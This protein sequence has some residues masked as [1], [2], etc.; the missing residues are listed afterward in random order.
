[1]TRDV[2]A[3]T[4]YAEAVAGG[5]TGTRAQWRD[6]LANLPKSPFFARY[7]QTDY[8]TAKAAFDEGRPL[9]AIN[10]DDEML[11]CHGDTGGTLVFGGVI[12][13]LA[14]T[15]TLNDSNT[16]N[17]YTFTVPEDASNCMYDN[18]TSGLTAW[19]VQAAI[20]EIAGELDGVESLLA[21]I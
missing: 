12:F 5:Y 16:W 18:T 10:G 7:G 3:V 14:T 2:G 1:M 9:Y 4:S 11:S 19:N 8:N 20:D 15:W 17:N 6:L 21:A 13:D